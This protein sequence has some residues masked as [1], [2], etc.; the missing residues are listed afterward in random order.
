M[1]TVNLFPSLP[2]VAFSTRRDAPNPSLPYSGFNICHYVGDSEAHIRE[3]IGKLQRKVG[4]ACF[5]IPFQVHSSSVA[6][7]DSLPVESSPIIYPDGVDALVTRLPGVALCINTADCVPILMADINAGVIAGVHSGW[8]GTVDRIVLKALDAMVTLGASPS[9]VQVAMGPSIC[10][11]CFQVGPEVADR[12]IDAGFPDSVI[13]VNPL[14]C[15][16]HID[17]PAAITSSLLSAG[18][19]AESITPPPACSRCNPSQFCSARAAGISSART[20]SL[21]LRPIC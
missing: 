11:S 14:S 12:F 4:P 3:C 2:L 20:L 8:R 1:T 15:K 9:R 13:D 18:V 6:V 10:Q 16:P 19:T 17:L 7:I 5:V 21:I